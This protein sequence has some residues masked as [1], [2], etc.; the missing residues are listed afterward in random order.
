MIFDLR[1]GKTIKKISEPLCLFLGNFDGVHEG[2]ARLVDVALEEGKAQGIKVAAYTF[3]EHPLSFLGKGVQ[4]LTTNEE[5]NEIFAALG[6]DYVIYED[7]LKV[8]NVEP[9][10]FINEI[11]LKKYNCRAVVCGFNFKFG[12]AGKGT[13]EL[14]ESEMKKNGAKIHVVPPI[15]K[16]DKVVSSSE[17][18]AFLENGLTE[19]AAILLGRP[20]SVKLPVLHGNE[21]GRTIGMP[22]INQRFPENRIK[23]KKGIYATK[24]TIGSKQYYGVSNVGSRPTVNDDKNDVNCETHIIGYSGWLYDKI[25]KVEFYKRLRDEVKFDGV[26][27]LKAAVEKD[28]ELTK[29]YFET[30]EN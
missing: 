3:A 22:T 8:R 12:K 23:I 27:E 21:I 6:V 13:P 11:L 7:F 2:H 26:S 18:R 24:C 17:I 25:V 1:N 29:Q 28:I 30:K 9:I 14:L 5:K 15:Y 4:T 16:M 19:E 20:Y 10:D